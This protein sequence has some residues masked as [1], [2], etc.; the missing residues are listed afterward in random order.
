M[1]EHLSSQNNPHLNT[2]VSS[3][4]EL[5]ESI[6]GPILRGMM[7][8]GFPFDGRLYPLLHS[9]WPRRE[10]KSSGFGP[11][12][13]KRDAASLYLREE[14]LSVSFAMS[15]D[16]L[17]SDL[18]DISEAS[19]LLRFGANTAVRSFWPYNGP[20]PPFPLAAFFWKTLSLDARVVPS[21]RDDRVLL[22]A[23]RVAEPSLLIEAVQP[24]LDDAGSSVAA[25]FSSQSSVDKARSS[26]AVAAPFLRET[27]S[28]LSELGM[29][30]NAAAEGASLYSNES[31]SVAVPSLNKDEA[32]KIFGKKTI[33]Q[34][35]R[36]LARSYLAFVC[37]ALSFDDPEL[38]A[39]FGGPSSNGRRSVLR[40][41][42]S[43]ID[44]LG[45]D[46]SSVLLA[47]DETDVFGRGLL[48]WGV[49]H[50]SPRAALRL[51][52]FAKDAN[53]APSFS[54]EDNRNVFV[55]LS[56]IA[57]RG[58]SELEG[59]AL[60][61]IFSRFC[62]AALAV[63]PDSRL[64][65]DAAKNIIFPVLQPYISKK[66]DNIKQLSSFLGPMIP[67]L[68]DVFATP[69]SDML[70]ND[71]NAPANVLADRIHLAAET[72]QQPSAT[73]LKRRL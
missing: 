6:G 63:A 5:P 41:S 9:E 14:A 8:D 2:F 18:L 48:S 59:S 52:S 33:F 62:N 64:S 46:I 73:I 3:L 25:G 29:F 20:K 71:S 38:P 53:L 28:R 65:V 12:S 58:T 32:A 17:R 60:G 30:S 24:W 39:N 68:P 4:A 50:L 19:D 13:K 11:F 40:F 56:R 36:N 23:I 67:I 1:T 66:N 21:I 10:M 54:D 35:K 51:L 15:N 42:K 55:T 61:V 47:A 49:C 7:S 45:V 43:D 69:I 27:L 26:F 34:A 57:R 31:A 44:S 22:E 70:N 72:W 37:S 16:E